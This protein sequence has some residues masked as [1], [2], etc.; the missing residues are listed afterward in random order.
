M[1]K[2]DKKS[3]NF[4]HTIYTHVWSVSHI[5][6]KLRATKYVEYMRIKLESFDYNNIVIFGTRRRDWY[7]CHK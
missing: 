7:K 2:V 1:G 6:E 5:Y 3:E 4:L